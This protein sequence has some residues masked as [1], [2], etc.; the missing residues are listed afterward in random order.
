MSN[1]LKKAAITAL[2]LSSLGTAASY[3]VGSSSINSFNNPSTQGLD[4]FS[5]Y[6]QL[7]ASHDNFMSSNRYKQSEKVDL[8]D[9]ALSF[10][11]PSFQE[12]TPLPVVKTNHLIEDAIPNH[13]Q[14]RQNDQYFKNSTTFDMPGFS[15]PATLGFVASAYLGKKGYSKGAQQV[16]KFKKNI[17]STIQD[18]NTALVNIKRT[19]GSYVDT[20]NNVVNTVNNVANK[21]NEVVNTLNQDVQK[22]K[23]TLNKGMVVVG[24]SSFAS[25]AL[26]GAVALSRHIRR[27]KQMKKLLKLNS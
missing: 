20:A 25:G 13:N 18:T 6:S 26:A 21:T 3:D 11:W 2:F 8:V 10:K 7:S 5:P 1:K 12:N 9:Q 4:S 15:I 16:V 23:S 22:I 14:D 27:K 17:T 19:V 24:V